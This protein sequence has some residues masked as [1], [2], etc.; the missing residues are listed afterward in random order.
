MRYVVLASII[1]LFTFQHLFSQSEQKLIRRGNRAYNHKDYLES[2]VQYRQAL[3]QNKH[4]FKA[5]FNLSG[6]QYKQNKFDESINS[7]EEI[8]LS[9]LSNLEKSKVYYNKGNAL[10]KQNKFKESIDAY[11]MALKNNPDDLEAKYN[12]SEA[13]RM[14][15]NQQ[16]QNKQDQN[17][18]QQNNQD[19]KDNQNDNNKDNENKDQNN[20]KQQNDNKN[21]Q[22]QQQQQ[23]KISKEDAERMLQALQQHEKEIQDELKKKQAKPVSGSSIKNW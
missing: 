19:K 16:N 8:N 6:A 18:N 11:R 21:Q 17:N 14:L 12:L 23:P 20:Q 9:G 3:E 13:I 2:E 7:L 4:S 5:K 22:K 15:Q 10:F 1:V